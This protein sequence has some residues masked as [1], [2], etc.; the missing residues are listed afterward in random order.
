[1]KVTAG[2]NKLSQGHRSKHCRFW[3]YYCQ[4]TTK[5]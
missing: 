1:M 4:K 3:S 5:H 2:E